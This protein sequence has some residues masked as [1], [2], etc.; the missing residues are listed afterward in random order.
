MAVRGQSDTDR[1]E[2]AESYTAQMNG[3]GESY[4]GI[5]CAEQRIAQ[6]G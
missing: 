1:W 3:N 2:K 6:E 4:S 5:V